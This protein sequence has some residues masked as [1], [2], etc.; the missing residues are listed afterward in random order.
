MLSA[1]LLSGSS[2]RRNQ[3]K[4]YLSV[5]RS[6][7]RRPGTILA[8]V[9]LVVA[10]TAFAVVRPLSH[11]GP[12]RTQAATAVSSIR[13]AELDALQT[14][15]VTRHAVTVD[16]LTTE[17]SRTVANPNGTLTDTVYVLPVRVRQEGA[18]VPVSATLKRDASGSWQPQAVPSGV[19]LSGGGTGPLATMTSVTGVRLSLSFP[20]KLPVPVVSGATATYKSVWPGT[21]LQVTVNTLGGLTWTIIAASAT[22]ASNPALRH[23]NL[24]ISGPD[25]TINSNQAGDLSATG[26]GHSAQFSGPPTTMW[27][28]KTGTSSSARRSMGAP[29]KSTATGP[30][31]AARIALVK[32]RLA[33]RTLH[34]V[35][36]PAMLAPAVAYPVYLSSSI[37]PDA[38]LAPASGGT[39]AATGSGGI[40]LSAYNTT[41]P[42]CDTVQ[43]ENEACSGSGNGFVETQQGC[44]TAANYD[45][46]QGDSSYPGNGIGYNWWDTCIGVYRSY[47]QFDTSSLIQTLATADAT[48]PTASMWVQSATLDAWVRY[49]ADFGCSDTWPVHLDWSGP[50][51][52]TTDWN[53]KPGTDA[54]DQQRSFSSPP[55]PNPDSSC[56]EQVIDFDVTYAIAAAVNSG[57]ENMTFRFSGDETDSSS[58]SNIGFM[59]IGNNPDIITVF[60]LNP[61]SIPAAYLGTTPHGQYEPAGPA[62]YGCGQPTSNLPW[63]NATDAEPTTNSISGD[64]ASQFSL[65]AKVAASIP[66]EPVEAR[67]KMWDDG[68]AVPASEVAAPSTATQEDGGGSAWVTTSATTISQTAG[69]SV[70]T[71]I[72]FLL[73]DGEQ[74]TWTAQTFVSG[75]TPGDTP[76]YW[77]SSA[78][79]VTCG[80]NVDMTPPTAPTV[81]ST[82][83]PAS[84]TGNGQYAGASGTFTFSSTDP[85]PANCN[86]C[87]T[88]GVYEFEY[89]LNDV[90]ELESLEGE[91]SAGCGSTYGAVQANAGTATS[92]AVTPALWGT[93]ILYVAALDKA[94]NIS[95]VTA[96]YFYVPWDPSKHPVPGDVNG[97]QI[98]DLL[99]TGTGTDGDLTLYKGDTDL[100]LSTSQ[101]SAE[102]DSPDGSSWSDYQ[103]T[104]RGPVSQV[105]ASAD[106]DDLYAHKNGSAILYLYKNDPSDPGIA[107]QFN[108]TSAIVPIQRPACT[109]GSDCSSYAPSWSD[110]TQILSPGDAWNPTAEADDTTDGGEPSL[111][112]VENGEL[113]AFQ[114]NYAPSLQDPV[115]LGSSGW[116]NVTLAAPG[117]VNNQLTIW[118]YD[119]STGDVYSYPI[120]LVNGVPSLSSGSNTPIQAEQ[121]SSVFTYPYPHE[122]VAVA[123]AGAIDISATAGVAASNL[124]GLFV[125]TP[126][127]S[128]TGGYVPMEQYFPTNSTSPEEDTTD[129]PD[130]AGTM[131]EGSV[132]DPNQLTAT[133]CPNGCLWYYPGQESPSGSYSL[134]TTPD[135]VGDLPAPVQQLS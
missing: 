85:K 97:D 41:S 128:G 80:F 102:A 105:S 122:G 70:S 96:Y 93:N 111:F 94:G 95:D 55:G 14:A 13:Q 18:W 1:K 126:P 114:G 134:D 77:S 32:G 106:V 118:A 10:G 91:V 119:N 3:V 15:E 6:A 31:V 50:I 28:S 36:V 63:I 72:N 38:T 65:D 108:D 130:P 25:L 92:C 88:S 107:P 82:V 67:Y 129:N 61:P 49:G 84:G 104:H 20:A 112:T 86:E 56:T 64:E 83:F 27:D 45:V 57:A 43:N 133:K 124:P 68:T 99:A 110:V 89:A 66:D 53:N 76:G 42:D 37:A 24:G 75:M 79:A 48:T 35:P 54:E 116:G 22:A 103:I 16:P 90:N 78:A 7:T 2:R 127:S 109:S 29:M 131:I 81:S 8:A 21:N 87:L 12:A 125:A 62:S 5:L 19:T 4:R 71:P 30:G 115:E 120:Y 123:S 44:P 100:R 34:L 40:K 9:V 58:T 117:Y 101:A 69:A 51:S 52:S 113:W 33:G 121:G 59:R 74:Y 73:Q 17:V 47:Y 60:D 23:L 39:P 11:T 26:P 46:S 135:F 132:F 98:P